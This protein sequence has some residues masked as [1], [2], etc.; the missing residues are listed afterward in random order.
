MVKTNTVT[1]DWTAE[2][3]DICRASDKL[4]EQGKMTYK[5]IR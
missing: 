1:P 2:D 5:R 3:S 4:V